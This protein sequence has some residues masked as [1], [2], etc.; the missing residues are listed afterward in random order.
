MRRSP[1]PS[2]H[3]AT[4]VGLILV[5]ALAVC[6]GPRIGSAQD[7]AAGV[8]DD[9][10]EAPKAKAKAKAPA[11]AKPG[12]DPKAGAVSDREAIGFT[13]ENVAAQMVEL[14]ERMFRL[15]EAL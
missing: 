5:V 9:A 3:P 10:K 7:K 13:Q 15:S 12:A 11:E 2:R 6:P 1:S 8:F 4:A 14:E